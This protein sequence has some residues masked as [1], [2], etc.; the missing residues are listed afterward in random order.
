M[1]FQSFEYKKTLGYDVKANKHSYQYKIVDSDFE[2]EG[3]GFA[4]V[5]VVGV[6]IID[7]YEKQNLPVAKNLMLA[8]LYYSKKYGYSVGEVIRW[9]KQY[10]PKFAKY[11]EELNKYMVLI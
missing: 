4:R 5:I 3:V 2:E 7:T 10:N 8:I 6:A 9:D 1:M 11:E